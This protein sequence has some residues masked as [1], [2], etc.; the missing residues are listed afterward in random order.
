MKKARN[1]RLDRK[2]AAA[3]GAGALAGFGGVAGFSAFASTFFFGAM[4]MII[5]RPSIFAKLLA[6]A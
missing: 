3:G 1:R 4:L 2:A 6:V 5:W